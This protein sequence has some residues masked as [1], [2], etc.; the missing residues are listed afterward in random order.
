MMNS[1]ELDE[2]DYTRLI[3]RV[4]EIAPV[5]A[6]YLA[7]EAKELAIFIPCGKLLQCFGWDDTPQGHVY[8]AKLSEILD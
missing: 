8:W 1:I 7:N 3:A 6:K 4:A 5:A 2:R